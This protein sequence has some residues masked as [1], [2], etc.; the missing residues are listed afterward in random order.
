MRSPGLLTAAA[1][2]ERAIAGRDPVFPLAQQPPPV[3]AS[4]LGQL[5]H[6]ASQAAAA[7]AHDD[8]EA[9]ARAAE[10]ARE[11]LDA[12]PPEEV[13]A[14]TGALP[15]LWLQWARAFDAAGRAR[16]RTEYERVHELAVATGQPRVARRAAGAAAWL[17]AERGRWTMARAWLQRADDTGVTGDRHDAALHVTRALMHTD[18]DDLPAAKAELERADA[19]GVGEFWAPAVWVRSLHAHNVA[20]ATVT[21]AQLANHLQEHPAALD[22]AGVDGRLARAARA[23]TLLLRGRIPDG[24]SRYVPLSSSDRVVA[25]AIAHVEGREREAFELSQPVTEEAEEHRLQANALLVHAAAAYA[26]DYRE[27][28]VHAFLRADA[29]IQHAGLHTSYECIAPDDLQ[30][31]VEASGS[32]VRAVRIDSHRRDLP[33]LTRRE[34][35]VLALLTTPLTTDE[36]AAALFI[37]TN[38]LKTMTRRLYRKLD[39]GSR[40]QAVDY[41][42]RAGFPGNRRRS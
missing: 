33:E 34:N 38:T 31:L 22:S 29:L 42:H 7:R 23:R 30:R 1:Q 26:L 36:I 8:V 18:G 2:L 35:D 20:D 13:E 6:L 37:S 28:A 16:A 5:E 19:I 9:A 27:T 17:H 40:A 39:V 32:D 10:D 21:E 41:A 12:A 11:R 14:I 25:A 3:R 4:L 15:R 24:L